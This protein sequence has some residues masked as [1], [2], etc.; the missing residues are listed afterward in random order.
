[1]SLP[2]LAKFC[3][4]RRLIF[5]I[6]NFIYMITVD[7]LMFQVHLSQIS[8][9]TVFFPLKDG[10]L[11]LPIDMNSRPVVVAIPNCITWQSEA[12]YI[13]ID[14]N[15]Y[16]NLCFKEQCKPP[17]PLGVTISLSLPL[18]DVECSNLVKKHDGCGVE[19]QIL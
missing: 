4:G 3:N 18:H 19:C 11:F 8:H 2:T 13:G 10:S 6:S 14:S 5:Y 15:H 16:V 12:C 17:T 1:M 7:M 9:T